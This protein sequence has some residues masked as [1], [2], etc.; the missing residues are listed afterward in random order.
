MPAMRPFF[1]LPDPVSP[2]AGA[3]IELALRIGP[4][5]SACLGPPRR[6]LRAKPG[7][8]G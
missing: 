2:Y 6:K 7:S 3:A 5:A 1:T 4:G 8:P